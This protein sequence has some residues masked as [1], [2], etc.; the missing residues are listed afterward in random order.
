MLNKLQFGV[1][2]VHRKP[3]HLLLLC[4]IFSFFLQSCFC[5]I[6][7]GNNKVLIKHYFVVFVVLILYISGIIKK[8]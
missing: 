8:I 5:L 3:V 1:H 2:T 4:L 6:C 7:Y